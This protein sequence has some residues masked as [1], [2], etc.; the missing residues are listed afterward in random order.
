LLLL[1]ALGNPLALCQHRFEFLDGQAHDEI[2]VV[3]KAG[4][5]AEAV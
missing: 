4:G 2:E 5:V 1:L 3:P